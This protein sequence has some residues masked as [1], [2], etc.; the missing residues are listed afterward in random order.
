MSMKF[1]PSSTALRSVASAAARSAGSPQMPFAGDPHGTVSKTMDG[2]VAQ[3][4]AS[5]ICGGRG[6]LTGIHAKKF[7]HG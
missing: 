7:L 3:L 4:N 1:T 2:E 5:C 6:L